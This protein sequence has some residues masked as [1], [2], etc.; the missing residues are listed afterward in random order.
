MNAG[1]P[2]L[3][4]AALDALGHEDP[5]G[6]GRFVHSEIEIETARGVRRG[7]DAAITWAGKH[8]DHLVRRWAVDEIRED[9]S[10]LLV[11]GRVQYVW[12]ESEEVGDE[13]AA[14]LSFVL[15]EGQI[16]VMRIHET[17]EEGL[18]AFDIVTASTGAP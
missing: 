8:Y 7:R 18:E 11:L 3:V 14:A 15:E 5:D 17:V 2:A 1:N 10:R 6:F 12:R 13:M 9:G 4:R 16:R